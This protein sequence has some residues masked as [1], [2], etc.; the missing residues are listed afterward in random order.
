LEYGGLLLS[1]VLLWTL[2]ASPKQTSAASLG[3][4][5]TV[6]VLSVLM[7]LGLVLAFL[8]LSHQ[9]SA[10]HILIHFLLSVFLL[11]TINNFPYFQWPYNRFDV[12]DAVTSSPLIVAGSSDRGQC[13]SDCRPQMART[14]LS[15]S[16][17]L[18]LFEQASA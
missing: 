14:W 1:V 18:C 7:S 10:G 13:M 4:K 11:D 16:A 2:G 3:V 6:K 8:K 15:G 17:D 9:V 12:F 5:I